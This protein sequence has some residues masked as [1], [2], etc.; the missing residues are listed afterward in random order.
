MS[1]AVTLSDILFKLFPGNI[2]ARAV[3]GEIKQMAV[4]VAAHIMPLAHK[5]AHNV[6]IVF[7]KMAGKEKGALNTFL[8]QGLQ[9]G[10]CPVRMM[11]AGENQGYTLGCG[12][13]TD[14]AATAPH[15]MALRQCRQRRQQKKKDKAQTFHFCF[16]FCL[17][18]T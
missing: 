6:G 8:P 11:G 3:P 9:N 5:P 7:H 2:H 18:E 10:V 16:Y 15:S 4:T 14:H 13:R 1:K 17:P 12:I